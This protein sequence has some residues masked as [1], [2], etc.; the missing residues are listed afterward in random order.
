LKKALSDPNSASCAAIYKW[1]AIALKRLLEINKKHQLVV[2]ANEQIIQ[3][4][5]LSIKL[6]PKDP[7]T[8]MELGAFYEKYQ[9]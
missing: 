2:N 6:D 3:Y 5:E 7:F 8:Y 9:V 1:Y 4:L